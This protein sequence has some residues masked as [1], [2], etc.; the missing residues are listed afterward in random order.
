MNFLGLKIW[1]GKEGFQVYEEVHQNSINRFIHVIGLPLIVYSVLLWIYALTRNAGNKFSRICI[2]AVFS[3]YSNFYQRIGRVDQL[4][5]MSLIF[6]IMVLADKS[7]RMRRI[8]LFATLLF[9]SCLVIQEVIGHTLFEGVNLLLAPSYVVNSILY[10]P[11][12]YSHYIH[13][14]VSF[15]VGHTVGSILCI[16]F[17]VLISVLLWS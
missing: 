4:T 1:L 3:A 2:I 17:G 6:P 10:T 8:K 9:I 7:R 13:Q 15:L 5:W 14:V 12:F 11:F 16:F